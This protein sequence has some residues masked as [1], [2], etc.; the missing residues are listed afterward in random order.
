MHHH[1]LNITALILVTILLTLNIPSATADNLSLE[2]GPC[3]VIADTGDVFGK[4]QNDGSVTWIGSIPTGYGG[5]EN[6]AIDPLTGYVYNI[7]GEPSSTYVKTP[8]III[9]P[10]TVA[11]TEVNEDTTLWDV[12]ALAFNPHDGLLY[13]VNKYEKFNNEP[14]ILQLVD[15]TTGVATKLVDLYFDGVAPV[16]GVDPHIDGIS[17]DPK[18]GDLYGIYSGWGGPSHLVTIDMTN[19]LISVIG[20]TGA[21]DIEDICFKWDGVL[22]GALGDQGEIE[23]SPFEGLVVIDKDVPSASK[24]GVAYDYPNTGLDVES[25]ACTVLYSS[26]GAIVGGMLIPAYCPAVK[27]SMVLLCILSIIGASY[28]VRYKLMLSGN[29]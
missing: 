17:F 26:D 10:E 29:H 24:F 1:D 13:A 12:D 15:K 20:N 6:L 19:G 23:G 11:I 27:G 2:E 28:V 4:V 3:Y 14:G 22:V 16:T 7:A 21:E 18:K 25:F 9:D 5:G 8:L